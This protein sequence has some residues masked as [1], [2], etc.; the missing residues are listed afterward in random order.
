VARLRMGSIR[1]GPT[2]TGM[3]Q[4]RDK[5]R[6]RE[7]KWGLGRSLNPCKTMTYRGRCDVW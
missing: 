2:T 3:G 4:L 1:C 5:M 6:T 7:K